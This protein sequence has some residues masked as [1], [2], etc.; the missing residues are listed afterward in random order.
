MSAFISALG[1]AA[2]KSPNVAELMKFC[3]SFTRFVDVLKLL[4]IVSVLFIQ[5]F[6]FFNELKV[7]HTVRFRA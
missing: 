4:H 7:N 1:E 3:C 2:L 6:H 5:E